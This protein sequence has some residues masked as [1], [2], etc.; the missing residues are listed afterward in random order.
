VISHGLGQLSGN[1]GTTYLSMWVSRTLKSIPPTMQQAA[2]MLQREIVSDRCRCSC[3]RTFDR[4]EM[5]N[6]ANT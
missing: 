6:H 1:V 4:A 2:K 3:G 5:N